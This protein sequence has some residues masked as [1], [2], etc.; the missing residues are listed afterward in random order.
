M[1]N[2]SAAH[3]DDHVSESADSIRRGF[4]SNYRGDQFFIVDTAAA[5]HYLGVR[6]IRI[7]KAR[8]E[9]RDVGTDQSIADLDAEF[10]AL[11]IS[12]I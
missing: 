6:L 11:R 8:T 9:G 7:M 5:V 2:K 12:M 1:A 4:G 3:Y 10:Q